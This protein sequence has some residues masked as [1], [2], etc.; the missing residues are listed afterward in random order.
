[1]QMVEEGDDIDTY[2]P[3][4]LS[5]QEVCGELF[6]IDLDNKE[7]YKLLRENK[8]DGISEFDDDSYSIAWMNM[9]CYWDGSDNIGL[10]WDSFCSKVK[11]KA[12]FLIMKII[13]EQMNSKS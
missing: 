6:E 7:F 4:A 5:L 8:T 9:G 13:A 12:R 11:H 1:M 10:Q 3:F 2:L